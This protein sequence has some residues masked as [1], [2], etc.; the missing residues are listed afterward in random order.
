MKVAPGFI[1]FTLVGVLLS[2]CGLLK[3][4]PQVV[5]NESDTRLA[6]RIQSVNKTDRFVL[7]RRYGLWRVKEGQVV[8]SRGDDGRTSN[9]IPT[10]EKLGEHVA[11]DIRSG[12]VEIGDSVYI[13]QVV[14]PRESQPTVSTLTPATPT[15]NPDLNPVNPP[16]PIKLFPANPVETLPQP[17]IPE[18]PADRL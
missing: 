17:T 7:I 5:R 10:G 12:D 8:V 3:K 6:G 13:R 11:A 18:I 9:L 2:S 1:F 14:K 15:P 16:T 4:K